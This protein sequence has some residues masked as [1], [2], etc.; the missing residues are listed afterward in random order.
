MRRS[1]AYQVPVPEKPEITTRFVGAQMDATIKVL[2]RSVIEA[3]NT[4]P[5]PGDSYDEMFSSFGD[6]GPNFS[7]DNFRDMHAYQRK[8]LAKVIT[9][10]NLPDCLTV[11]LD[12]EDV[13]VA[14]FVGATNFT[15]NSY[16]DGSTL[17]LDDKALIPQ[18]KDLVLIR[19][20]QI[21][22]FFNTSLEAD[23]LTAYAKAGNLSLEGIRI[24]KNFVQMITSAANFAAGTGV[25]LV[26]AV[27][28]MDRCLSMSLG[29]LLRTEILM[30]DMVAPRNFSEMSRNFTLAVTQKATPYIT[31][32]RV[33]ILTHGFS[34]KSLN[35]SVEDLM[36]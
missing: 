4:H 9:F 34:D 33:S 1:R 3:L 13:T 14:A 35:I 6:L 2:F 17:Q 18:P 31:D 19:D 11:Q 12:G 15:R 20:G 22:E 29:E 5:R 30:R 7:I 27:R 32:N 16:S 10:K 28:G 26:A 24:A 36:K 8:E 25:S 21:V 23:V